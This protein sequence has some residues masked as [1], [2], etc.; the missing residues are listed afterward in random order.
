MDFVRCV[1]SG[2]QYVQRNAH[3]KSDGVEYLEKVTFK[4]Y[5]GQAFVQTEAMVMKRNRLMAQV[6]VR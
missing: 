3:L 5:A 1:Q 6:G 2:Q 4:G